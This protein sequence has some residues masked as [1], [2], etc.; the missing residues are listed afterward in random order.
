MA[1]IDFMN[2]FPLLEDKF[3]T[4]NPKSETTSNVRNTKLKTE[5][6]AFPVL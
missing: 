5:R 3:E 4:R 1:S 6:I 2:P